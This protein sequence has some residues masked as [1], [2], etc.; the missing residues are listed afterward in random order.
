LNDAELFE[1]QHRSLRSF[2]E[3]LVSGASGDAHLLR[4][5]GVLCA[6]CPSTPDR[7]FPN[8]V[9]YDHHEQLAAVLPDVADH[10]EEAGV[11][12]WTVWVPAAAADTNQ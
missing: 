4:M 5:D 6:V 2:Y 8:A 9:V 10:Y 1:R 12:A 11:R 7:S 3:L